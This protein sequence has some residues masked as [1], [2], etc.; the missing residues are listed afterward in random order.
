MF[1]FNHLTTF[2]AWGRNA[3]FALALATLAPLAARAQGSGG[4]GVP[5]TIVTYHFNGAAGNEPTVAPTHHRVLISTSPMRRGSGITPSSGANT[6]AGSGWSQ[7]AGAIDT[8]DY[9]AF[10]LHAFVGFKI[11][12]TSLLLR[13]RRSNTG[14]RRWEMRSSADGF[15][16][17]LFSTAVPD[18]DS[19][20]QWAVNLF[21]TAPFDTGVVDVEFRIYGYEAEAAG[22]TWRIDDILLYGYVLNAGAIKPTM[23]FA[24]ATQTVMEGATT[25]N[26]PVTVTNT[27]YIPMTVRVQLASMPGTATAGTDFTFTPQQLRFTT[28][29]GPGGGGPQNVSLT[30]L[31]D[32]LPEPGE[33]ILL[34]LTDASTGCLVGNPSVLTITIA[35]DDGGPLAPNP[36]RPIVTTTPINAQGVATL[37][38]QPVRLR[39]IVA[40]PN[41]RTQGYQTTLIDNSGGI[42]L[43]RTASIGTRTMLPGD[44]IEVVGI[45]SQYNGLTQ[46]AVD[47]FRTLLT[48]QPLPLAPRS[49]FTLDET[50]ESAL[51]HLGL[52]VWLVNPFQWAVAGAGFTV[53]VTDGTTTYAMRVARGTD[54]YNAPAPTSPFWLTGIGGQA[55]AS[56][57]YDTDYYI[58]PRSLADIQTV[59]TGIAAPTEAGRG[60][61]LY[62]NPA[63]DVVQLQAM[64]VNPEAVTVLDLS[65]RTVLRASAGT[66]AL[67]VGSLPKGLY[68]VRVGAQV[69]RLVVE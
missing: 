6:F 43:F 7:A 60:L 37:L 16:A 39:G 40:A 41:Q 8:A 17:P 46:V 28:A 44:S 9:F 22:G 11:A 3:L 30:I 36:L 55:D 29:G 56:A 15:T 24:A 64:G 65:G 49:V 31:N 62:P 47:S 57:P 20:R 10:H 54:V 63:T 4:P 61:V 12:P 59:V 2:I 35:D 34:A 19:T 58:M 50:T 25:L 42:G 26:I 21:S 1:N 5:D 13:E 69:R 14:I 18:N 32:A 23:Q 27:G 66:T 68:V 53:D 33:T 48:N 38:G 52:P 45:L 67:R 51:V